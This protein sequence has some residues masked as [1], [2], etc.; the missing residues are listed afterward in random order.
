MSSSTTAGAIWLSLRRLLERAVE[1]LEERHA[2]FQQRVVVRN[3]QSHALDHGADGRGL[4]S[5][6]AAILQIEV[7]HD[8]SN[9]G[10]GRLLN[11]ESVTERF[12]RALFTL[13]AELHAEHVEWNGGVWH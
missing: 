5:A 13:V 3:R 8:G 9:A 11:C 4:L 2:P 7:V 6:E 10:N 12:K 1:G